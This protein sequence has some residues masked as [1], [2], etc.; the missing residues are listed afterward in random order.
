MYERRKPAKLR[1]KP[2]SIKF[3]VLVIT[4]GKSFLLL[5]NP[6]NKFSGPPGLIDLKHLKSTTLT[7]S[8]SPRED[9]GKSSLGERGLAS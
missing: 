5:R 6:E 2:S 8:L 3:C 7:L 1:L 9:L 4:Y